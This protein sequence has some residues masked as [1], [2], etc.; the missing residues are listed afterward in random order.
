VKLRTIVFKYP[1]KQRITAA[2]S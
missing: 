2:G 1:F